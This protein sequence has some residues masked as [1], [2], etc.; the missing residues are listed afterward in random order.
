MLIVIQ[1]QALQWQTVRIH[2]LPSAFTDELFCVR[3]SSLPAGKKEN[4]YLQTQEKPRQRPERFE[5]FLGDMSKTPVVDWNF[6]LCITYYVIDTC[7]DCRK[8]VTACKLQQTWSSSDYEPKR[9][10]DWCN[11]IT[12]F[13]FSILAYARI[14]PK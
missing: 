11:H 2:T 5:N 1:L 12:S 9:R 10:R 14:V 13:C 8:F 3:C 7:L 4:L 6:I